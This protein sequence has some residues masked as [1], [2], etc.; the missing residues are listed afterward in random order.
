MT[1]N[2]SIQIHPI[3]SK[4]EAIPLVQEQ[5]A[6][7]DKVLYQLPKQGRSIQQQS[8]IRRVVARKMSKRQ[9]FGTCKLHIASLHCEPGAGSDRRMG[10]PVLAQKT[11]INV[12]GSFR[13]LGDDIQRMIF[14]HLDYQSLIFLSQTS[15][16]FHQMARPELADQQDQFQFVMRAEKE[17]KQHF[18]NEKS[19][20]NFACY[21]CYRVLQADSF[22]EDQ[23]HEAFVDCD[24]SF[25]LDVKPEN[26]AK[27]ST[28]QLRRY[29]KTCGC[30]NGFDSFRDI[31]HLWS[32]YHA[33]GRWENSWKQANGQKL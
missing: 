16:H 10:P 4:C 33:I 28:V 31:Q 2:E 7:S 12:T 8:S 3:A 26:A 25:V 24:G 27:Y 17:F 29:C 13:T 30:K 14:S 11:P 18:P 1:R 15:H 20:G 21:F 22:R 19:P 6:D 32:Q 23:A 5:H 9:Q